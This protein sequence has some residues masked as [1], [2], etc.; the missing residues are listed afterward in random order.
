M[1][2]TKAIILNVMSGIIRRV[3]WT[4]VHVYT[5]L[6]SHR[7]RTDAATARGNLG[8]TKPCTLYSTCKRGLS[9]NE[10]L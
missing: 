5:S 3:I 1:V 2:D 10:L 6:T 9:S 8:G 7:K 4:E